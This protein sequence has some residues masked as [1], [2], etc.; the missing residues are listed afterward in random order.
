V[1]ASNNDGKWNEDGLELLINVRPPIWKTW[2]F[3][4]AL[5]LFIL[6]SAISFYRYRVNQIKRQKV[7]LEQ[8]VEKRT[9]EVKTKNT[10]LEQRNVELHQQ[11]EEILAQRDYIEQK[12]KELT[13]QK[14]DLEKSY[15]NVQIL[16]E[17]G[18]QVISKLDLEDVV[19]SV[20][21]NVN[22]LMDASG[23]GIGIY[24]EAADSIM[25]KGYIE[26]GEVLPT[27]KSAFDPKN[28]LASWCIHTNREIFI[29]D[30]EAEYK[31]YVT[32]IHFQEL[33]GE[34]PQSL[35]YLPLIHLEKKIGV[36]TVQSFKKH[37]YTQK[38]INLLR[39]L[40]IYIS[41]AVT[42]AATYYEV[43]Q[44]HDVIK[45]KN[46]DIMDSLRYAETI[47]KSVL[48][49][50]S[51]INQHLSE[52]F[53]IFKPKDVV[54]GDFYWFT[55]IE[56]RTFAAVVDC[57]GHGVPGAFMSLIGHELLDVIVTRERV[58]D[59][60][61]ILELMH[62]GV[63]S[64]L[65]QDNQMNNDGMDVG[66]VMIETKRN[67]S[68]YKVTF[69]GAK[70]PL[71]YYAVETGFD[72]LKGDRKSVGG[73]QK[74]QFVTF[75]NHELDLPSGSILYLSSDGFVDQHSL[76]NKKYGTKKLRKV[77]HNICTLEMK[78]QEECLL[79]ELHTHQSSQTQRDDIT[80]FGLKL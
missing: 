29:N 77:L 6:I 74:D 52:H 65:Q 33:E 26:K 69:A 79:N 23:F 76:E 12:N 56:G 19:M 57:T 49:I 37:A 71:F 34:M 38:E 22:A 8:L 53:V 75:T 7:R 68:P 15:Q 20:Y 67:Q 50:A 40:A 62:A 18:N 43:K 31:H 44:A 35:I 70:R 17:I 13:K 11:Q 30:V 5:T 16:S 64:V 58:F 59:P 54:S 46:K 9:E 61:K 80:L 78:L 28:D 27:H 2:W 32:N 60:A 51:N 63:R 66:L 72:E 47:Q 42:N 25:F 4:T 73:W 3:Q 55:H 14:Q 21:Q 39:N 36:I 24:D 41:I 48:P 45:S 10:E 1:K